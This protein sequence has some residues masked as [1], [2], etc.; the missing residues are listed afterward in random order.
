MS[1]SHSDGGFQCKLFLHINRSNEYTHYT[2]S[3]PFEHFSGVSVVYR[4]SSVALINVNKSRSRAT[5]YTFHMDRKRSLLTQRVIVH[6][7]DLAT[8]PA[9]T[10]SDLIPR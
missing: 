2:I 10:R 3:I 6:Y 9:R 8:R 4:L 5:M 1:K 7:V